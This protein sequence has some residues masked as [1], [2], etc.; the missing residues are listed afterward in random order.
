MGN[1]KFAVQYLMETMARASIFH[2]LK[3]WT[4]AKH[5]FGI[6]NAIQL[7]VSDFAWE[8]TWTMGRHVSRMPNAIRVFALEF[9]AWEATLITGICAWRM[10]NAILAFVASQMVHGAVLVQASLDPVV[11]TAIA[12]Q[13]SIVLASLVFNSSF[14]SIV[15]HIKRHVFHT[16]RSHQ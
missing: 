15:N 8:E 5:V 4:M 11:K 13:I 7:F 2:S 14:L 9:F 12:S 10:N 6:P 3:T 1:S 16:E